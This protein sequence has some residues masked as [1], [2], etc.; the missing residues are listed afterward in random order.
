MVTKWIEE[1]KKECTTVW[2]A[3]L[4]HLHNTVKIVPQHI[5]ARDGRVAGPYIF[6][7]GLCNVTTFWPM[8]EHAVSPHKMMQ[9]CFKS[10]FCLSDDCLIDF[11]IRED[12]SMVCKTCGK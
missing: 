1:A 12:T 10:Q 4:S 11:L 3:E 2:K 8:G 9:T 7:C 5:V 6:H